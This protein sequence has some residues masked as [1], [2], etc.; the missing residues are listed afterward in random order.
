MNQL[1]LAM[2]KLDKIGCLPNHFTLFLY[3]YKITEKQEVCIKVALYIGFYS[4]AA[5]FGFDGQENSFAPGS[6]GSF[7]SVTGVCC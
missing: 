7:L 4:M 5:A 2:N 1:I 3:F 6:K